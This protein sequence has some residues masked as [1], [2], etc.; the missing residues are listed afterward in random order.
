MKAYIE[1]SGG[2][3]V[4]QI[5]RGIMLRTVELQLTAESRRFSDD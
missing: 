3:F 1:Y 5:E 2:V 4:S